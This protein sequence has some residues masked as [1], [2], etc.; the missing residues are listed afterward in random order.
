[1]KEFVLPAFYEDP[2]ETVNQVF[3]VDRHFTAPCNYTRGL[4]LANVLL[5][6]LRF[7][8]A[9]VARQLNVIQLFQVRYQTTCFAVGLAAAGHL[10]F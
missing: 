8:G 10:R 5:A 2:S 6:V 7:S 3:V 1:M 9:R 4:F